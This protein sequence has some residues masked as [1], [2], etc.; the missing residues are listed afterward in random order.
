[1]IQVLKA[2]AGSGKTFRLALEYIRLLL[3]ADGPEGYRNILAVTFTNKATEE[4]KNRI[5]KELF[6]LSTDPA[7]SRYYPYIVP[8]T[9]PDAVTLQLRSKACLS[10]I[11]HDYSAFS[12]STI[13]KFFQQT[14]RAFSR[15][16][17]QFSAY[18]VELD[19]NSLVQESVDRILDS[20]SEDDP[21]LLGWL[22]EGIMEDLENDGYYSLEPKLLEMA[23]NLKSV[24]FESASREK[25]ISAEEVFT[26]ERLLR[27]MTVCSRIKK[28]FP[29]DV[30]SAAEKVIAVFK[31]KDIDPA[32]T[33][34]GFMTAIY[35]Y[36]ALTEKDAVSPPSA[37]F[38]S[39]S[40][41]SSKWFPK[42]RDSYRLSLEGV[43]DGPLDE[44]LELFGLRFREYRTAC[45][46]SG[47]LYAL[48]IAGELEKEFKEVQKDRSVISIDDSNTILRDIIDGSD[49]P[50]V[51]EKLGVRYEHFLLDEF[52][53]TS[54][55]Q[56]ENFRPLIGNSE[57]GGF[58]NLVVGDVKQ[59]IY[60]WRG[61]DWR[62]LGDRIE[63]EFPS[64]VEHLK[65]NRR[66]LPGIVDFN[67]AFFTEAAGVLGV[68]SLYSD[69]VQQKA[70][71][72]EGEGSVDLVFTGDQM[73]AV[74]EKVRQ[75]HDEGA[76]YGEITVLVR[77]NDHGERIASM[78]VEEGIPVLSDD[79]LSVKSS[80]T[81]RRLVSQLSVSDKAGVEGS[82]EGYLASLMGAR[83][84]ETCHS[85]PD[86]AESVLR[87]VR[88]FDPETFAAET[89]YILAFMDWLQDWTG[90]NGNDLASFLR[91][92][93]A[94]D[95]MIASP[96]T[97][98]SV[99]VMT[100]H[101]SKGLEF[102][103]VIFPF[104][105]SVNIFRNT[106]AWCAP[107]A[108]G[109]ALDEVSD[110]VYHVN[111]S[112][113]SVDTLFSDD[114]VE[115]RQLQVTDNINVFYVALTRPC[116]GMT[117]I[118]AL[119]PKSLSATDPKNMS[120]VLYTF[121]VKSGIP[122][123]P[124]DIPEGDVRFR[125][126]VPF[127]PA[128]ALPEDAPEE[129]PVPVV[130]HS[131]DIGER[132]SFGDEARDF[133]GPEGAVG[134]KASGRIRG[135]VLHAVLSRCETPSDIAPAVIAA[136]GAGEIP[137]ADA[138]SAAAFL[139]DETAS[140]PLWYPGPG[141]RILNEV[142]VMDSAGRVHRPD[143][144]VMGPDGRVTVIDYKFPLEETVS[145]RMQSSYRAQV[146]RYVSLFRRMGY[147]SVEGYL[148][149]IREG[150]EDSFEKVS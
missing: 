38:L 118:A 126:G 131:F 93:N 114:Y 130:C 108:A 66:T 96:R 148:W 60:R 17:G 133:F 3:E 102:H 124:G 45:I 90:R 99:R 94:A 1:M 54:L 74:L 35:N 109:T 121:A 145:E 4:M 134:E 40:R 149:Y 125:W 140:C 36:S 39:N 7:S 26:R 111:L 78:L 100:V 32:L 127:N 104:A 88:R 2:S 51:Y 85:L 142:S 53:D 69:V 95:P 55:L 9:V 61:S 68:E 139:R 67:N 23:K 65:T 98:T 144:V 97:K 113:K 86:L 115:E 112:S 43:L 73:S 14:L 59:S 81:V 120:Q 87:D 56:W 101:K 46:I 49:A 37:A 119:P 47:G 11:V 42:S 75:L 18:Q 138:E 72:V 58:R 89:L 146:R 21:V 27:T 8:E 77:N 10:A 106:E 70:P 16:I 92:W 80:V 84:G 82:V 76:G 48:G 79:S 117:V 44:F 13:D 91:D 33:N 29:V 31:A 24:S 110:A 122:A 129:K 107:K 22:R 137:E 30:S 141:S 41:D 105:E 135:K 147:E 64:V 116:Y 5:L 34:R 128:D 71:P 83:G 63:K 15:E 103:Y 132:L 123:P 143:R 57:A 25:G 62:L 12:V 6:K 52:Q 50:F 136:V 19:R 20:L 150:A 28:K